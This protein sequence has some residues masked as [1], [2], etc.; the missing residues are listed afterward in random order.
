MHPCRVD[1]L[2]TV[3]AKELASENINDAIQDAAKTEEKEA[4][5]KE[6]HHYSKAVE[7][8]KQRN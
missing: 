5:G 8:E 1:L 2:D 7:K 3:A 6:Q 4:K